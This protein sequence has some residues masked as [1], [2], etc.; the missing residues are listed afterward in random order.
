MDHLRLY[1][2]RVVLYFHH[3]HVSSFYIYGL[4]ILLIAFVSP[5]FTFVR[6]GEYALQFHH[7]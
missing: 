7:T 3:K 6:Q 5:T 4:V 2:L 1:L